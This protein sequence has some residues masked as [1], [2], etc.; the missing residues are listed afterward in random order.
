M[1]RIFFLIFCCS[2]FPGPAWA[3]DSGARF[4]SIS[5]EVEV[6]PEASPDA[7]AFANSKTVLNADD[8]VTTG[9]ESNA[10]ITF[11][12]L[13]TLMMKA[14]SEIVI[15]APSDKTS[16]IDLLKGRLWLNVKKVISGQPIEVKSN[17][18]TTG[19]KGTI[20][21]FHTRPD[22]SEDLIQILRGSAEV[23]VLGTREKTLL[24]AGQE[25]LIKSGGATA[26]RSID[27]DQES[28]DW[29]AELSGMGSAIELKDIP[30]A[31]AHMIDHQSRQFKTLKDIGTTLTGSGDPKA[32]EFLKEAGRFSSALFENTMILDNF[33]NKINQGLAAAGID[34]GQKASL[35]NLKKNIAETRKASRTYLQE[36]TTMI[37]RFAAPGSLD[38]VEQARQQMALIWSEVDQYRQELEGSAK[39]LS[40]DWFETARQQVSLRATELQQLGQS[41]Q[42]MQEK[43]P[44]DE[45]IHTAV[46][47]GKSYEAAIQ[48]F[49]RD[50]D[51]SFIDSEMV[52]RMQE[53]AD[54]LSFEIGNLKSDVAAYPTVTSN[55]QLEERLRGSLNLV[56]RFATVQRIFHEAQRLNATLQRNASSRRYRTLEQG[57]MTDLFQHI[58]DQF[59]EL[60]IIYGDI[61]AET[62]SLEGQFGPLLRSAR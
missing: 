13:S 62:A 25:L 32:A 42:T 12:D 35:G 4:S 45:D 28:D 6:F 43:K 58:Q 14:E 33:D 61:H 27:V 5:R 36:L 54:L 19:I 11:A 47:I 10:I 31:I 57:Q 52:L 22:Q 26:K 37:K 17:L 46:K 44:V 1:K 7:R 50:L 24:E 16:K 56:K 51:V 59:Q 48:R 29:K 30:E 34:K 2:I 23:T 41:L 9:E 18:A 8:H 60:D 40:Q 49:L 3:A 53:R 55:A 15:D 38:T 20:A 21:T 39:S